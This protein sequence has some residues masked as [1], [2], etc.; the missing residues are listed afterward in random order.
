[1]R[2][3]MRAASREA[4]RAERA[5]AGSCEDWPIARDAHSKEI[6]KPAAIRCKLMMATPGGANAVSTPDPGSSRYFWRRRGRR[7]GRIGRQALRVRRTM[8][9]RGAPT[10]AEVRDQGDG[11]REPALLSRKQGLLVCELHLLRLCH[12]GVVHGPRLEFRQGDLRAANGVLHG[13]L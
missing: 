3:F 11:I 7:L 4:T 5:G 2:S 13:N 12:C 9:V 1:M 10:T 8:Q 6:P